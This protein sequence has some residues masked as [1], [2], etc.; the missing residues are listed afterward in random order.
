MELSR[1]ASGKGT[2]S[3]DGR[4]QV[5]DS[6]PPSLHGPAPHPHPLPQPRPKPARNRKVETVNAELEAERQSNTSSDSEV[7]GCGLKVFFCV[8]GG[9]EGLMWRGVMSVQ[10][11][12]VQMFL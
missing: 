10:K 5:A 7:R 3:G 9:C 6:G 12:A 11:D 1:T 4:Q 2:P 8:G